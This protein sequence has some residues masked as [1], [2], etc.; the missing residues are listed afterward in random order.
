MKNFKLFSRSK[1]LEKIFSTKKFDLLGLTNISN[2]NKCIKSNQ[3]TSDIESSQ[4]NKL[5]C[6]DLTPTEPILPLKSE[7]LNKNPQILDDS[8]F[9][10]YDKAYEDSVEK[11]DTI[12][13]ALMQN[14]EKLIERNANLNDL[15]DKACNLNLNTL[16]LQITTNRVKKRTMKSY[17]NIIMIILVILLILVILAASYSIFEVYYDRKIKSKMKKS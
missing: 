10:E 6:I 12:K 5:L 3:T 11:I 1:K 8:L 4:N 17:K 13:K 9:A 14:I 16:D 2:K 15:Q 7:S